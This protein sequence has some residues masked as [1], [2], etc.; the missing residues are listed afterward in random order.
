MFWLVVLLGGLA[1][2]G[3]FSIDTY[4]P[5]FPAIAETYHTTVGAVEITLAVY[6]VGL[7]FGQL[8]YGP[9]ADS[10]GRKPPLYVGLAMYV[11]AS[12]G[13][14]FAPNIA[15]LTVL[16]FVQAIGGCSAMLISRTVVR[17]YFPPR[18]AARVFSFL[19]L[20][21]GVSPLVAPMVG[22]WLVVHLGWRS[23][24]WLV[25]AMGTIVLVFVAFFLKESLPAEKRHPGSLGKTLRLYAS[26][27]RDSTF[28]VYA[29]SGAFIAAGMFAYLEGSPLVFIELNHVRADHFGYFFGA[30]AVGLVLASQL[31]G[32]LVRRIHPNRI[33]RVVLMVAAAAGVTLFLTAKTGVGGFPGIL[34]ALFIF[35]ACHGFSFPN[36]TALALAP[37]GK[38]A[39]SAAAMLGCIQYVLGGLGGALVSYLDNG[40]AMPMVS[41]IAVAA[42]LALMINLVF[43]PQDGLH[44]N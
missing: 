23:N 33:F 27:L 12:T 3:P 11:L 18:E 13:C 1:A 36:A 28:M 29:L 19:M 37:H 6:F 8:F 14:V 2:L 44:M 32:F 40:T 10:V 24:F 16:R 22:G 25:S 20:V 41:V 35:V 4:L 7:C 43:A 9:I 31:N 34:I 26:L 42:I 17:D 15:S 38:S 21:I 30:I 5:A 39:G